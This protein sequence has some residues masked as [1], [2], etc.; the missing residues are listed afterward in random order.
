MLAVERHLPKVMKA[1]LGPPVV[2][3]HGLFGSKQNWRSISKSL[4]NKLNAPVFALDLPNHGDSPWTPGILTDTPLTQLTKA[5]SQFIGSNDDLRS[6]MRK[7][8]DRYSLL[9]HSL[10]GRVAMMLALKNPPQFL[11]KLVVVD[12]P[13]RP[14]SISGTDSSKFPVYVE[15]MLEIQN[16]CP[17]A[18]KS[19][20]DLALAAVESDS[21]IRQFL[22]TNW[23]RRQ[24]G[25]MGF[26]VNL[27]WVRNSLPHLTEWVNDDAR[28]D[29][30]TLFI[31]GKRSKY[32][33]LDRDLPIIRRHFT[34]AKM[35]EIDAGHWVHAEQPA[36]FLNVVVK[37]LRDTK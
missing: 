10:G 14:P 18:A 6:D 20:I 1:A 3:M 25:Q 21:S 2:I 19:Q 22:M 29:F 17:D 11:N 37:F 15:T 5:V 13:P 26:R 33:Q 24:D 7:S 31:Y 8:G 34:Q 32:I 4:A 16:R 36:E 23:V 12:M 27:E 35:A 9:G 28:T 30:S